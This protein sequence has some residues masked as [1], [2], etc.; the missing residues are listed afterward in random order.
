MK[1]EV[2]FKQTTRDMKLYTEV[3]SKEEKSGFIKDALEHYI[4]YLNLKEK[5][6]LNS[7]S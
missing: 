2:S 1:I 5:D 7:F 4:K 3:I 6:N